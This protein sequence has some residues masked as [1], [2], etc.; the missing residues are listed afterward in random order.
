MSYV[1]GR[2]DMRLP[3]DF[4]D[5]AA[6]PL[7]LDPLVGTAFTTSTGNDNIDHDVA[8][9]ATNDLYLVVW[10]SIFSTSSGPLRGQRFD[11]A[12]NLVGGLQSFGDPSRAYKNPHVANIASEDCFVVAASGSTLPSINSD[13]YGFA[14]GAAV[15]SVASA[16]VVIKAS[17][18]D[19]DW[20]DVGGEATETG[21]R[22]TVVWDNTTTHSIEAAQVQIDNATIPPTITPSPNVVTVAPGNATYEHSI[23]RISKSGGRT[24]NHMIVWERLNAGGALPVN[25]RGAIFSRQLNP[26]DPA[27]PV[28]QGPGLRQRPA[29]DGDGA[30]WIVAWEYGTGQTGVI[31]D[32][33]ARSIGY[34]PN[35]GAAFA[36]S[37]IVDVA[38]DPAIRQ[39]LPSVTWTG[40]AAL[41]MW[42]ED[43]G[44]LP[45]PSNFT[46]YDLYAKPVDL[47]TALDAGPEEAVDVNSADASTDP[48]AASKATGGD[49]FADDVMLV[50]DRRDIVGN[51]PGLARRFV[52]EDG[53]HAPLGGRCGQSGR[54]YATS[55]AVGETLSLR[56]RGSRPSQAAW[57][58]LSP[59]RIDLSC[60]SCTLVPDPLSG[61]V[62]V[63]T[64][65]T[66]GDAVIPVPLPS[67]PALQGVSFFH[68]WL[69]SVPAGAPAGCASFG[70]DLSNTLQTTIQ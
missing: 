59:G 65:D 17:A 25:I 2:V 55:A 39:E 47:F 8:Y 43:V 40:D 10:R 4:V 13:I 3:A 14:V 35:A 26:L 29:V 16:E 11:S 63:A 44:L 34:D 31:E 48:H 68:Q 9:D 5:G 67:D 32:I 50:Y 45:F 54:S 12:G 66:R 53:L 52:A 64:T 15:G 69:V 36:Q 58:V 61:F 23:P 49:F 1:D 42:M 51:L 22:A 30:N 46:D 38:V 37:A 18:D 70:A 21:D 27:F 41:I 60:G 56:L 28:T 19:L 62:L 33:Q 6:L 7:V 24:G 57:L 20:A